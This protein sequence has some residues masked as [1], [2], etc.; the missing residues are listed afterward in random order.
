MKPNY[1]ELTAISD[2]LSDSCYYRQKHRAE[3][4]E[5]VF[6]TT[7]LLRAGGAVSRDY[8]AWRVSI[9]SQQGHTT[10]SSMKAHSRHGV[11]ALEQARSVVRPW[12]RRKSAAVPTD[13]LRRE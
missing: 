6:P 2:G 13:Q 11:R 8:A 10:Q 12:R 1:T 3:F 5:A 7:A 9:S 4:R